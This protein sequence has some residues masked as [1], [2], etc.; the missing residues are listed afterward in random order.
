MPNA[1][2]ELVASAMKNRIPWAQDDKSHLIE[3]VGELK[4][5]VL[6]LYKMKS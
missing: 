5:E 3:I 6:N 2:R 1:V 4:E